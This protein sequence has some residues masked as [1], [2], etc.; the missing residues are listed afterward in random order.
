MQEKIKIITIG[1]Y[2]GSILED[3]FKDNQNIE[4]FGLALNEN[5][6]KFNNISGNDIIFLR[7][8]VL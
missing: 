3:Y 2:K 7:T 8:M 4:F 1:D 6:E 5:A